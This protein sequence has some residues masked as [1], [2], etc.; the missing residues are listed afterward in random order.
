MLLKA[1]KLGT[2]VPRGITRILTL[3]VIWDFV[4]QLRGWDLDWQPHPVKR[5]I[6]E[7][8]ND[9]LRPD[10]PDERKMEKYMH[11]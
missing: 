6:V 8:F 7:K 11:G 4:L 3:R 2:S 1:T 9:R 5:H 10:N